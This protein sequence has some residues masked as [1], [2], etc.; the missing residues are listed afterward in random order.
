MERKEE[1]LEYDSSIEGKMEVVIVSFY[2]QTKNLRLI[3][4]KKDGEIIWGYGDMTAEL[5]YV[6]PK[7]CAYLDV[8]RF[9]D[10]EK[11]VVENGIGV[12]TGLQKTIG[13]VIYPMYLF[14]E[15]ILAK[16]SEDGL[17]EYENKGCDHFGK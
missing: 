9:P 7:Y 5:G 8:E 2:R 3:M 13:N 4:N 6:L 15:M 14:N 10:I 16:I 17:A 11:F 1:V 12:F